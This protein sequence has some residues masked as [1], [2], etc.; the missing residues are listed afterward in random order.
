MKST[1]LDNKK[2]LTKFNENPKSSTA[3]IAKCV[4]LPKSNVCNVIKR[5]KE[6]LTVERLSDSSRKP[7]SFDKN[8][9]QNI[10]RSFMKI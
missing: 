3:Y 4:E 6:T 8:L 5:F 9:N 1:E 7:G 2:N 10:R